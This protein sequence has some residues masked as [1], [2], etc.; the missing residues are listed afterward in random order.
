MMNALGARAEMVGS[1]FVLLV[2][3]DSRPG[4]HGA[5]RRIMGNGGNQVRAWVGDL[6]GDWRLAS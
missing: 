5:K 1:L 6:N 3:L 4:C 2:W